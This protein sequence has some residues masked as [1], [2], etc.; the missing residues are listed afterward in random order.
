M[1]PSKTGIYGFALYVNISVINI[2]FIIIFNIN[3][4][5]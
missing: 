2:K 4:I 3:R 1:Y 5:E